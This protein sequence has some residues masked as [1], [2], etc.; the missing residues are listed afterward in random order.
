MV[1]N[2]SRDTTCSI[3]VDGNTLEQVA[4]Y[5]YLGSWVTEDGRCDLDV[6]SRIGMAKDVF[7]KHKQLLKGNI[8]LKVKKR[9]LQC[10]VFP[11]VKYSC[12]SWTLNKD[13]S[14][15]INAFEQWCYRRLLKIKWTD[16]ISNEEVLRRM[17]VED[18]SLYNNIKKQKLSFAGHLLRG[19]A[20]ETALQILEG[21]MN[22]NIAQGRPRRMWID[23]V[24][25]WMNLD[26][27]E[28]VKRTAQDRH[29]WRACVWTACQ[30]SASEDDS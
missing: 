12:K 5:K 13:L 26:S 11:V 27:Y 6:K 29:L 3:M 1:I 15:R 2:K 16:K 30:P 24:K 22:S 8:N 14:R 20:G 7:W 19:S 28:E 17:N 10:Y 18:L 23:D 4:Q 21:R 9:I 25:S